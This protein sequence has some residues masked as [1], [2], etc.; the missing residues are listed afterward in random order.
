MH[1]ADIPKQSYSALNASERKQSTSLHC[2]TSVKGAGMVMKINVAL[3]EKCTQLCLI[4]VNL[5]L[6]LTYP[7]FGFSGG[8]SIKQIEE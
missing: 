6:G 8:G 7:S 5:N 2:R 4:C 1:S 3:L